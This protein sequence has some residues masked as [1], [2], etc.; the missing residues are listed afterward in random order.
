MVYLHNSF[1]P[2]WKSLSLKVRGARIFRV[3][4]V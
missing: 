1:N 3:M 2:F 4:P